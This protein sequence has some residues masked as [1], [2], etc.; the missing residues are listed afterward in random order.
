MLYFILL[1][2]VSSIFAA[3]V[4][5]VFTDF[6]S[7]EWENGGDFP[8]ALPI[9]PKWMVKVG[10]TIDQSTMQ[11]GDTFTLHMPCV[12]KFPTSDKTFKLSH[13]NIDYASCQLKPGDVVLGY[14][15]V[16]CVINEVPSAGSVSGEAT[17]PVTF[18]AGLSGAATDLQCSSRFHE[19]TN[20]IIFND[21]NT[22]ISTTVNFQKDTDNDFDKIAY[23][24]KY[25]PNLNR[26]QDYLL[27]G[28]CP[29]GYKSGKLGIQLALTSEVID[30][31]NAKAHISNM[32]NDWM[33]P[34]A[35]QN[36]IA[37]IEC[38]PDSFTVEYG[39]IPPGYRPFITAF[40]LDPQ[41]SGTYVNYINTYTCKGEDKE[42]ENDEVVLWK[43]SNDGMTGA[44]AQRVIVVTQTYT[45]S[46]T[47]A[48]TLPF[49]TGPGK[50]MTIQVNVPI[51]T[52]TTTSTYIGIST[53][54]T[55]ISAEPGETAIVVVAD[56]T[57]TTITET[58][59]WDRD[60]TTTVTIIVHDNP[61][62]IVGI[63]T[64]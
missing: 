16:S 40:L 13:N 19:G 22:E 36:L 23:V 1:F 21:G 35:A 30:C 41:F 8:F 64:P 26:F 12:Y 4:S 43:P 44:T 56:P 9:N 38:G 15:E 2:L 39:E 45:G 17:F 29:N 49:E 58:T 25:I 54:Y 60:I 55:T 51:P 61:T 33:Y 47:S 37:S 46:T 52:I 57:H 14:S 53:S 48:T 24:H 63:V 31:S 27:A 42:H 7:C 11:V 3:E 28:N 62:D 34:T 50:T 32:F 59:C 18:N 5:P 6:I 10:W 20:T